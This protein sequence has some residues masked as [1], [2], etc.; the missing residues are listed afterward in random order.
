MNDTILNLIERVGVPAALLFYI[1]FLGS[2]YISHLSHKTT[3]IYA[4]IKEIAANVNDMHE[5]IWRT[6]ETLLTKKNKK[7]RR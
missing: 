6:Y 3:E 7:G 1:I 4:L 2:R 5:T